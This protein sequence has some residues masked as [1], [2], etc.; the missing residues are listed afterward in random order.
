MTRR[1][2]MKLLA[3][4][5]ALSGLTS[6]SKPPP[7]QIVPSV[8]S[9]GAAPP[10]R[11]LHFATAVTRDG[12][13]H[14]VVVKSVSGRPVKVEGNPDHPASLGAT[15][16]F[17]QAAILGLYDPDRSQAVYDGGDISTWQ[18]AAVAV[19]ERL[20]RA[21]RDDGARLRL[22]T[23]PTT[24]PT[25][26]DQIG[27]LLASYPQAKWHVHCPLD[28]GRARAGSRIAFGRA[29]ETIPDIR[30][31]DVIVALGSDF[32]YGL[33]GSVRFAH[34]WAERRR[35]AVATEAPSPMNRLYV[36]EACPSVTGANADHRLA[37]ASSQI[38]G[39]TLALARG[40]KIPGLEDLRP[41]NGF[42]K[43]TDQWLHAATRDLAENRGRG[44]L[45]VG[46][47]Q[48]PAV[49][50][51]AHAINNHLGNF[52]R[53]IAAAEAFCAADL[54]QAGSLEELGA[55]IDAGRV[56]TL[57]IIDANPVYD[58]P[59]DLAFGDR[60]KRVTWIAHMGLY[61]DET[62]RVAHSHLPMAHDLES[63]GD[64]RAFDGTTTILQPLIEPL[65]QGRTPTQLLALLMGRPDLSS[66][67][68]VRSY[69]LS[70]IPPEGFEKWWEEALQ[71]GVVPASAAPSV[72]AT[73]RLP[74]VAEAA[75]ALSREEPRSEAIELE[76]QPDPTIWDGRH[77]N[78][79]WLQELPKPISKLTWD[80][81]LYVSPD[82]AQRLK[83]RNED[84]VELVDGPAR[85]LAP[86]WILPGH[87]DD[88]ATLSLGYGRWAAGSVG[89]AVGVRAYTLRRSE[90]EWAK[91]EVRVPP[92]PQRHRMACTQDHQRMEG[93][94]LIRAG[95]LE[96]YRRE[97]SLKPHA[98]HAD[99]ALSFFP[100]QPMV[101]QQWGMSI[102]LNTCIGCGACTIACQAENNIP[103]VGKEEVRRGREMHWIRVDRY[104]AGEPGDPQFYH[105]PVP[106]MHCETA[107]CELVC[108]VNATTHS[109]DGL[110]EMTY[111]RCVGTRYCSNNCPYKVRRFNFLQYADLD[112]PVLKLLRNPQV[113]VRERG[114]MEKCTYCVQRIREAQIAARKENRN[115]RDGEVLTA[116]QQACPTQA[117]VF[118]DTTDSAS[119]V[120]QAKRDPRTYGL[121][122][123]LNT[124]PR[125][126][127]LGRVHNPRREAVEGVSS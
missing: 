112:T 121:L 93:R 58:A 34:E 59:A 109:H 74:A 22:L 115:V 82:T 54:P 125:T 73:V 75:A 79:G 49:H 52:G 101:G 80:N 9:D 99:I 4:S 96:D 113:S 76:F 53:T 103:I 13:A 68:L 65:Y 108:P 70:R 51:L 15:D 98:E 107:P 104:F 100:D 123:H 43:R 89:D 46:G 78:N 88:C 20:V 66:R 30:T 50:A 27:R 87:A 8:R 56:D 111:N 77:A 127:Y 114:V 57:L 38:A 61:R 11:A 40:L 21:R 12:F 94:D 23:G 85:V 92:R 37:V 55:D 95:K 2:A 126:T 84:V 62:A 41:T 7:E 32:L 63:W 28:R 3:A 90:A 83:V 67:D 117:I 36:A 25:L 97:P 14:G 44:L 81:A 10:D 118:G 91:V 122:A 48:P 106:C 60:L 42:D 31:A 16:V 5:V 105:Q 33:A 116:C 69:W 110:N 24:S 6:C 120:A 102:D 39:L 26:L 86:V 45:L 71:R 124:R 64:A 119:R 19:E 17:A 29:V 72:T 35:A 1:E 47:S 18:A